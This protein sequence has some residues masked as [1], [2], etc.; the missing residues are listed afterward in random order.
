MIGHKKV[1][2]TIEVQCKEQQLQSLD[3]KKLMALTYIVTLRH[4]MDI[5]K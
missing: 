2:S 5:L 4:E 3:Y 1:A